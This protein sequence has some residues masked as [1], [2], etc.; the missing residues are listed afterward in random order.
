MNSHVIIANDIQKKLENMLSDGEGRIGKPGVR[1]KKKAAASDTG[2]IRNIFGKKNVKENSDF[3][4]G[5][6]G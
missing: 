1:L 4:N 2:K 3:M 6:R 5:V